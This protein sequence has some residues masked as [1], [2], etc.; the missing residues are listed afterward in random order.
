MAVLATTHPTMVDLA[1]R[2]GSDGQP[3]EVAEVLAQTNEVLS[4]AVVLPTNQTASHKALI[5]TGIPP[6]TWMKLNYG[7]APVKGELALI[8]DQ[9]AIL[10]NYHEVAKE[11]A[12]LYPSPEVYRMTEADGIIEGMSQEVASNIFY[13]NEDVDATKFT[14]LAPR[15]NSKSAAIQ[16]SRNIVDGGGTGST[17]ASLWLVGWGPRTCHLLYPKNTKSGLSHEDLGRTTSEN[18]GGSGL[19]MEIYRSYFTWKVGLHV[20]DWRYIVRICN[21]DVTLL[22]GDMSTGADLTDLMA[23]ALNKVPNRSN[24]RFAWYA[25]QDIIGMLARQ[26]QNKKNVLLSM[27]ELKDNVGMTTGHSIAGIP[28]RRVDQLLSTEARVT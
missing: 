13:G 24:A 12:D 7:I 16:T 20:R 27:S 9:T 10:G 5:R 6:A 1:M 26:V 2:F 23:Q 11:L 28:V 19:R 4:D 17:N 18:F 25:N 15:F 22:K 3:M 8:E 21:I 14:G